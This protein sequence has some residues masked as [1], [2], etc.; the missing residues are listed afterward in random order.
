MISGISYVRDMSLEMAGVWRSQG[1][2]GE[3][4]GFRSGRG[5][6]RLGARCLG[7]RIQML[8]LQV[9]FSYFRV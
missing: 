6:L 3:I 8:W 2:T 7:S 5:G 4:V 1:R 9:C